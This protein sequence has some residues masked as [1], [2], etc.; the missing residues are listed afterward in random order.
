MVLGAPISFKKTGMIGAQ[1]PGD[2][3][4]VVDLELPP[5]AGIP[6]EHGNSIQFGR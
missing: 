4:D 1:P 2:V 6:W 3:E 5:P